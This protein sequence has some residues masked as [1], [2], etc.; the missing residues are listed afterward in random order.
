MI[1]PYS[2]GDNTLDFD[3]FVDPPRFLRALKAA[4][5]FVDKKDKSDCFGHVRLTSTSDTL[6]ISA[7]NP[8]SRFSTMIDL[9]DISDEPEQA[10]VDIPFTIVGQIISIYGPMATQM[11]G[12]LQVKATPT[13]LVLCDQSGLFPADLHRWQRFCADEAA[14]DTPAIIE[15]IFE[16][17][18]S[19]IAGGAHDG[20]LFLSPKS[21]QRVARAA[22]VFV[23]TAAMM[24]HEGHVLTWFSASARASCAIPAELMNPEDKNDEAL[25]DDGDRP[26]PRD[27]DVHMGEYEVLVDDDDRPQLKI[28]KANP[29]G[30]V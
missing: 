6:F 7:E 18:P 4:L 24:R 23:G 22:Q 2:P 10:V 16:W 13:T 17:A 26:Q 3:V 19:K 11:D 30:A 20:A 14:P 8:I 28:V 1:D 21:I 15:S 27:V 29:T 5:F 12:Q 25:D 9:V